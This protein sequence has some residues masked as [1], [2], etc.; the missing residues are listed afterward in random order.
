MK[1]ICGP[2]VLSD[3]YEQEVSNIL[4]SLGELWED[5][6]YSLITDDTL[7]LDFLSNPNY[8]IDK[9]ALIKISKDLNIKIWTVDFHNSKLL[10]EGTLKQLWKKYIK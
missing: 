4:S 5:Y 1:A 10:D 8:P 3:K 2:T 6:K 9:A 7:F